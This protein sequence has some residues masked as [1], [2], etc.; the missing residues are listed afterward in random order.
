MGALG[1]MLYDYRQ[2]YVPLEDAI[3][4]PGKAR[5]INF[6][7]LHNRSKTL[8]AMHVGLCLLATFTLCWTAPVARGDDGAPH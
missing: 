1:L 5:P 4:P 8:N 2:I 6:H 3:T 7:S